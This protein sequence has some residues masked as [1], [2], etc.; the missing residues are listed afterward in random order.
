MDKTRYTLLVKGKQYYIHGHYHEV[1]DKKYIG[2]FS[3]NLYFDNSH[4]LT[5][6]NLKNITENVFACYL[7]FY[8]GDTYYDVEKVRKNAEYARQQMEQR[9]LNMILKRLVNEEFDWS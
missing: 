9:S 1:K 5:F 2:E 6:R 3:H 7:A 4:Y 8:P